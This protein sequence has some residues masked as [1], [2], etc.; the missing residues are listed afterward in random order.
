MLFGENHEH[1]PHG[2]EIG[3]PDKGKACSEVPKKYSGL[4][5]Q[6]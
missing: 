3:S 5:A 4:W 2:F 6:I 1:V